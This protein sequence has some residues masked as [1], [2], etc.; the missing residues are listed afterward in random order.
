MSPGPGPRLLQGAPIAAEMRRHLKG[1]VTAFRRRH[2][3]AP[4]LAVVL[5]GRDAPS[6]V[7][8]QQILR[9]CRTVGAH[10][11]LVELPAGASAATLQ[12]AIE[13]L[14]ADPLV[15]GVIVQMP[16]PRRIPLQA[17]ID[18]IDP[19]KDIDG[20]HPVNAGLLHLGYQGFLPATAQAAVEILRRSGI[21]LEGLDAVVVGRSNVVG[22]PAA[23]L[24]LREHCT[25]TVC[26]RRTR[27]LA[28]QVR[29]ADL[30][31]AAAGHAGLVTGEML[32]KGAV[33]VDVGINVLPEGIV[34]D[35]DFASAR[36]VV[37]AITPVPGGV[38]PVTNAILLQHLLQ[39]ARAQ[40]EG[41]RRPLRPA[42]RRSPAR[43]AAAGS[44]APRRRSERPAGEPAASA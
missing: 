35:V 5:V 42:A 10:G 3:F 43:T 21:A 7:Y 29:R 34:G 11:R 44:A 41:G 15:S 33:V 23:Q 40:V 13:A 1:E 38:G 36:G 24:L 28:R 19:A 6:A 30:V 22:K 8:L 12:R 39:A 4:T 16:L 31:V 20:I 27:D 25:V 26:H 18:T 2:G 37:S 9:S 17:V 32:K 14:N